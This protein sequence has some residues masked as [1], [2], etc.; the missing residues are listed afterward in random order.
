MNAYFSSEFVSICQ[1]VSCHFTTESG[2][3]ILR[4]AEFL[5]LLACQRTFL[6]D[7]QSTHNDRKTG[8]KYDS[9]CFR[10]YINV[11]LC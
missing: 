4:L 3:L 2:N 1:T 10:I 7:I 6:C 11:K 9:C 8:F 5:D